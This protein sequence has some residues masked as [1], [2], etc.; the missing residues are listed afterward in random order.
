MNLVEVRELLRELVLVRAVDR[1][2]KYFESLWE[3]PEGVTYNSYVLRT[4]EGY[5]LFDT[6]KYN[7]AKEYVE[8]LERIVDI[9]DIR[10]VV[11]Q[12]ME[13]DHSGAL[14]ELS[15]HRKFRA[16]VLG[17]PLTGK[18]IKSL[19]GVDVK[20]KPVGDG[21]ELRVGDKEL[22]F[23][24]APWLHWPETIFTYVRDLKALMT[25]DAF[26]AYSIPDYVVNNP[27]VLRKNYAVFMRK[28]FVNIIGR[29]RDYVVKA[30]DKITSL[31]LELSVVAPSHG[32]V[33][34]GTRVIEEAL[35]LYRDWAEGKPLENKIVVIYTSMYGYNEEIVKEILDVLGASGVNL[36]VFKFTSNHRDNVSDLLGQLIDAKAVVLVTST[37]ENTV[38][39]LAKYLVNLMI[40]KANAE[41][42][43]YIVTTYGWSDMALRELKKMLEGSKFK[44]IRELSVNSYLTEEDRRKLREISRDIIS[45]LAS[46]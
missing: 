46:T 30:L 23:I 31:N 2:I 21:E 10:Y 43:L 9:E 36:E 27:E 37:Y 45:S 38:F 42:K 17:H 29:Y 25:C 28:Y 4:S 33:L 11:A 39:P 40:E 24:H 22:R 41:K 20:F 1:E 7:F 13:P 16:V 3:I 19:L 6:V 12:H 8:T 34:Q 32:A 5:V 35:K 26:G 15:K 14:R 18:L 44:V